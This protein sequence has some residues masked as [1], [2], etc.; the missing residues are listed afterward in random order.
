MNKEIKPTYVTF[1]QAKWLKEI[2]FDLFTEAWYHRDTKRFNL[3]SLRFSINKLTDNYA[4]PE[5]WEL[6]EWLRVNHGIWI[7]IHGWTN[8]P[9]GN[10][11]W[12]ECYQSFINGDATDVSIFKTPQEAYSAAFDY[13]KENTLKH[14]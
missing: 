9:V 13:I 4:A 3:N 1:E 5:H 2:G 6:V 14:S 8:Q 11:T 7:E 12:K 10:E